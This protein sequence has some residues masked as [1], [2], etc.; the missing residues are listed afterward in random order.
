MLKKHVDFLLFLFQFPHYTTKIVYNVLM[1]AVY[2]I[3]TFYN[4]KSEI[5]LH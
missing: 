3:N 2:D 5:L 1:T 4:G